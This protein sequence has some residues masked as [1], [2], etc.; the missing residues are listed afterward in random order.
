[1]HKRKS[2]VFSL[3]AL[4]GTPGEPRSIKCMSRL[5]LEIQAGTHMKF[6]TG[7]QMSASLRGEPK[8]ERFNLL[9]SYLP[10]KRQ[11]VNSVKLRRCLRKC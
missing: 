4:P 2:H 8:S 11:N 9:F 10:T 3:P 1:M 6:R 7:I 5:L